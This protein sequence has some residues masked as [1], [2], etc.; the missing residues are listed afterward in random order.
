MFVI[1]VEGVFHSYALYLINHVKAVHEAANLEDLK[2]LQGATNLLSHP[3]ECHI[4][5]KYFSESSKLRKHLLVDH[6][7]IEEKAI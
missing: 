4:C 5:C 3:V 1:I 7:Q 6:D 2:N